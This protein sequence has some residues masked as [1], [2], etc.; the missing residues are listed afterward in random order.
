[1]RIANDYVSSTMWVDIVSI[2]ETCY[3]NVSF[4][5]MFDEMDYVISC[6]RSNSLRTF[7]T[8]VDKHCYQSFDCSTVLAHRQA[9]LIA[10]IHNHNFGIGS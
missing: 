2:V 10:N 1:M 8:I 7:I 4:L 9:G 3:L 5:K 6:L